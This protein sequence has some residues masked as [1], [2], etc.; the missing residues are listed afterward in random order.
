MTGRRCTIGCATKLSQNATGEMRGMRYATL[1]APS[2]TRNVPL[3][4]SSSKE[5]REHVRRLAARGVDAI[6]LVYHAGPYLE[7][8]PADTKMEKLRPDVM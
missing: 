3:P 8:V 5:A 7:Y 6:K 4:I 1:P 2:P